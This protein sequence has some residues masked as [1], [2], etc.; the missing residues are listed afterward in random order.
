MNRETDNLKN[1]WQKAREDGN[2]QPS[3]ANKIVEMAKQQIRSSIKLQLSTIIILI[4]V[5]V[6][7]FAFFMCVSKFKHTFSHIGEGLMIGGLV[8]RII[9]ELFRHIP[10][11]QN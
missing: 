2:G 7:L 4:I 3:D 8:V 1:L 5:A 10:V 11:N 6:G 9:I